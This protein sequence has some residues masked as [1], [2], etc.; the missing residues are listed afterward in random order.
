MLYKVE[1]RTPQGNLLTLPL[2]DISDGLIVRD[3]TGLD[4]V[5]AT[6]VSS[7]F[8]QQ[9][10]AQYQ[11]S[12]R[13]T[14]NITMELGLDPTGD[15]SVFD[16]RSRLYQYFMSKSPVSLRFY[17]LEGLTVDVPGRVESCEASLFVQEPKVDISI[18]C[19][20]PDFYDP[21][22]V[23]R[24]GMTTADVGATNITYNGTV[25]TGM[26]ISIAIADIKSALTIY[27]TTPSGDVY[28]MDF[29]GP[30]AAGDTLKI[31]TITGSKGVT[32][33]HLGSD[34]SVLY[35]VSLQSTWMQLSHGVNAMHVQAA[36]DSSPVTI[37]YTERYGGL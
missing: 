2:D 5:K 28:T 16:L 35:G 4:P 34:S 3:I 18:I 10:G 20:D 14:R 7:E 24:T 33:T 9:D 29:A 8:A 30:L 17:M 31:S 23:V 25:D 22:P 26:E 21:T 36:G 32:L 19:F 15:D 1:V 6:I 13:E 11:S 27:Q 37:T 12:R